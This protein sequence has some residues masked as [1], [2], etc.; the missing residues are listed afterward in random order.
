[1][2]GQQFFV[3][4]AP[5]N[6]LHPH[7]NAGMTTLELGQ[8]RLDLFALLTHGPEFHRDRAAGAGIA[9]GQPQREPDN[10]E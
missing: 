2:G 3:R 7:P 10:E 9:T 8:Q 6:L 4:R 5:G 1:M